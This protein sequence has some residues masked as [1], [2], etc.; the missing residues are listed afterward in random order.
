VYT[1]AGG[2]SSLGSEAGLRGLTAK[3]IDLRLRHKHL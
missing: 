3:I 1:R 2:R